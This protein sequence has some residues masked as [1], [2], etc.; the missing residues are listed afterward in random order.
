MK[1]LGNKLVRTDYDNFR[2]MRF[3]VEQQ[4]KAQAMMREVEEF[5]RSFVQSKL[6]S[7]NDYIKDHPLY[8]LSFF[9]S[10]F[11]DVVLW[12]KDNG[13]IIGNIKADTYKVFNGPLY[14]R[15][16]TEDFLIYPR[17]WL[18]KTREITNITKKQQKQLEIFYRASSLRTVLLGDKTI[19]KDSE[20]NEVPSEQSLYITD[21]E[22]Y[23]DASCIYDNWDVISQE[24]CGGKSIYYDN[25]YKHSY[26]QPYIRLEDNV[27][28]QQNPAKIKLEIPPQVDCDVLRNVMLERFAEAIEVIKNCYAVDDEYKQRMFLNTHN[29]TPDDKCY[30]IWNNDLKFVSNTPQK[31]Q[32]SL[33][34]DYNKLTFQFDRYNPYNKKYEGTCKLTYS[35]KDNELIDYQEH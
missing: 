5:Q 11:P 8:G 33:D 6:I 21:W 23:I 15:K 12:R 2:D 13:P 31:Y 18:E 27:L 10:I 9:D 28:I 29:I 25:V 17:L 26:Y 20:D 14:V 19:I 34:D 1:D 32:V 24:L 22:K 35:T 7:Y 30:V 3:F 4:R 16:G